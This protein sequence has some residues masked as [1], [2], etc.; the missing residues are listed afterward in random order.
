MWW[1]GLGAAATDDTISILKV[2]AGLAARGQFETDF[3]EPLGYALN[4]G[5][6]L[7]AVVC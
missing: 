2:S 5:A 3:T 7:R 6:G 4:S 1:V